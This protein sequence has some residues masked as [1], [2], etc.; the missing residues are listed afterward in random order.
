MRTSGRHCI[1][2]TALAG[3]AAL[4]CATTALAQTSTVTTI[5]GTSTGTGKLTRSI[6]DLQPNGPQD[7]I[8]SSYFASCTV[9]SGKTASQVA[10]MY[11]DSLNFYLNSGGFKAYL[12]PPYST[13]NVRLTKVTNTPFSVTDGNTIP[14]IAA[15]PRALNVE[16]APLASPATLAM[17]GMGLA[18]IAW[19][20]RRR[21]RFA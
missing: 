14:G 4:V 7:G 9:G 18:G 20:A 19:W 3:V 21:R 13:T 17:L 8:Q 1:R 16:D 12:S 10:A 15:T 2:N 5:S 11:I 6:I